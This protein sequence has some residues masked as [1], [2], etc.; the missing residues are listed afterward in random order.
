MS[1]TAW[2]IVHAVMLAGIIIGAWA[3]IETHT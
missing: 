1:I 3:T 2:W